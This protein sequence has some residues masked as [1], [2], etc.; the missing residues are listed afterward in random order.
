MVGFLTPFT[1]LQTIGVALLLAV[2]GFAGGAV[3]SAVKR[4]FG[5]KDFGELIP[6][7]GDMLDRLDSLCYAGPVFFHLVRYFYY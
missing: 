3:M 7:H 4:D 1:P 5:V 2:A 6:G